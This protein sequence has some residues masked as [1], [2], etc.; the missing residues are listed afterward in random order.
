VDQAASAARELLGTL[1]AI[2]RAAAATAFAGMPGGAAPALRCVTTSVEARFDRPL[3]FPAVHRASRLVLAAGWVTDPLP[4]PG[5]EDECDEV[6]DE[7][8]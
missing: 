3:G 1:A 7:V 5:Y 6:R 2:T 8:G 4:F